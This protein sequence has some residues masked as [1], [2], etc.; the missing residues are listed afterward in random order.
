MKQ[1]YD[2][3]TFHGDVQNVTR[4]YWHTAME[5]KKNRAKLTQKKRIIALQSR[6]RVTL[7]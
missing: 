5:M 7:I 1:F 6:H 2:V 3:D 4:V